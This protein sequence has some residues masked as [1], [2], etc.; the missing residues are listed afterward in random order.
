MLPFFFPLQIN[1][2]LSATTNTKKR[3]KKRGEN[4]NN[5]IRIEN[6]EDKV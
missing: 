3:K 6:S 5:N 1:P 4:D 2:V